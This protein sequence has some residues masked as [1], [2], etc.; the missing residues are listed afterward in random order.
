L[1]VFAVSAP[2]ACTLAHLE[3]YVFAETYAAKSEA[4]SHYPVV[5]TLAQMMTP[6]NDHLADTA[7]E[8][9]GTALLLDDVF[10]VAGAGPQARSAGPPEPGKDP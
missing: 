2:V 8:Y 9:Q 7:C 1:V 4:V 3:T 10:A 6:L 5:A